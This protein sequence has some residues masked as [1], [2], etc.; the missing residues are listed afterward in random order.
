[1][2]SK[3]ARK[4]ARI[5]AS[6]TTPVVTP[7]TMTAGPLAVSIAICTYQRYDLIE[8]ALRAATAQADMVG[9]FEILLVDNTPDPDRSMVEYR[10][11]AA[12]PRLRWIHEPNKGLSRARNRAIDEASAPIIAFLDDDAVPDPHWLH[13]LMDAFDTLGTDA[14]AIGGR[15]SAVWLG[16]RPAWL[17]DKLLPYLSITDLGETLRVLDDREWIVG[18][19]MALRRGAFDAI[20][21]FPEYL[22]RQGTG[23]TLLSNDETPLLQAIRTQGA[24]VGYA[25]RA[26]VG[27]LID[28]TRLSQAWFRRRLA[29]Q[30]VSDC[31]ENSAV[32]AE[33]SGHSWDWMTEFLMKLP[34][35][36]RSYRGLFS[37][38]SDPALLDHQLNAVYSAMVCLLNGEVEADVF[39]LPTGAQ[40]GPG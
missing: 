1:M 6:A 11:H 8:G 35:S 39:D 33:R 31:L 18:A 28:P 2:V 38:M 26:S 29:W 22:G 30:A 20:G 21:R 3:P 24:M 12:T 32:A 5:R 36:Q 37:E 7:P 25:P 17:A 23:T 15:V 16:P 14:W 19:N 40:K 34:P 4:Q 9:A 13:A 27:H 10:R